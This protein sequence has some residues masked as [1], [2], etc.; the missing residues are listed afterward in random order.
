VQRVAADS[1][2][3]ESGDED[4]SQTGTD[5]EALG[6]S[7]YCSAGKNQ[8]WVELLPG[9]RLKMKIIGYEGRTNND[10]Q[11]TKCEGLWCDG[12]HDTPDNYPSQSRAHPNGV[13]TTRQMKG[14]KAWTDF[15]W[16]R[17]DTIGVQV[18]FDR[19]Y[20]HDPACN[21]YVTLH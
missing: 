13:W 20:Y 14:A 7:G 12:N 21:F 5:T 15:G 6:A 19:K 4:T 3:N 9:A 8:A 18:N 16:R 17:G 11:L 2:D 1:Q 10:A